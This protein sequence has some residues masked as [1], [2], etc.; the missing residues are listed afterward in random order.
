MSKYA[1][2][3][4][5]LDTEASNNDRKNFPRFN[6]VSFDARGAVIIHQAY[7]QRLLSL[8]ANISDILLDFRF[9]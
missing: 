1:Q 4:A 3:I 5:Y 9:K 7:R 2:L 8:L 6:E